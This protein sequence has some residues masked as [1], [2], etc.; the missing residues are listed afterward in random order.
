M[1]KGFKKSDD[2]LQIVWGEVYVP[3]VPDSQHDFMTELEILK[4]S[5]SWMAKSETKC[6][7]L[8]H[9]NQVVN[10]VVVESFI[11]REGDPQFIPGAWVVG[12]HIPDDAVWGMVKKGEIN[13]FSMQGRGHQGSAVDVEVPAEVTGMT[14]S[15][16]G[17]SHN[18]S[19][20]YAPN[21]EFI[22]G[23]TDEVDG[24]FHVIRKG[25]VT[26]E[27]GGHRHAFDFVRGVLSEEQEE[28]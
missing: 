15:D 17:H 8:N 5:Y 1:L 7:D 27:A 23:V 4:M 24:H 18:F 22:G 3:D 12:V 2:E 21:G 13:G 25:T 20:A 16:S 26:E 28:G 14:K 6:I 19:V 10:A 11:A 9:D